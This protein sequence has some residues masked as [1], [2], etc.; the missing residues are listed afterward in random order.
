LLL[1][2]LVV[3]QQIFEMLPTGRRMIGLPAIV[4]GRNPFPLTMGARAYKAQFAQATANAVL[5]SSEGVSDFDVGVGHVDGAKVLVLLFSPRLPRYAL[6]VCAD[7]SQPLFNRVW[8]SPS[9]LRGQLR[10]RH[11]PYV[12]A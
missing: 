4:L 5:G 8:G 11:R 1:E 12:G 9:Q 3:A 2:R 7:P 10:V 6:L